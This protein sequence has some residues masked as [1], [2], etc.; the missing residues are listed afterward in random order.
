MCTAY[1]CDAAR[2]GEIRV[3]PV[4]GVWGNFHWHRRPGKEGAGD[5]E[6]NR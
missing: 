5:A 4:L 6:V 1:G 3:D 2:K